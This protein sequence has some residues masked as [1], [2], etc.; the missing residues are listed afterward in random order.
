MTD[1]LSVLEPESLSVEAEGWQQR[2][3]V[4]TRVAILEA[5]VKCLAEHGYARTTT[6]MIAKTAGVSRGAMLHHY[7]TKQELISAVIEFTCYRRMERFMGGIQGLS[8]PERVEQSAGFELYWDSLQTPEFE[9]YLELSVAARTDADLADIF[10]PAARRFLDI[11][12]RETARMF[13]EWADK[14]D[15][16][17]LASDL[18]VGALQGLYLNRHLWEPRE[19]RRTLRKFVGQVVNAL[20]DGEITPP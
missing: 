1:S 3:S 2:K 18:T 5:A 7:A 14:L 8:E 11:E 6:Q 17:E 13:P 12:R 4:Q 19:R 16:L 9:A 10:I 20:R 15:L